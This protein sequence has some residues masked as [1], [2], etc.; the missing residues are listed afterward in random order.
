[1]RAALTAVVPFLAYADLIAGT[2]LYAAII[3]RRQERRLR[4]ERQAAAEAGL[5]GL[6]RL[7]LAE[8]EA[9]ARRAG[10]DRRPQPMFATSERRPLGPGPTI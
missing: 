1:M 4:A 8:E 5:R 6:V 10:R 9:K 2:A 7:Y 3:Q